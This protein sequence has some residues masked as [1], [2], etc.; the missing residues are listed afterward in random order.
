MAITQ[1]STGGG[2]TG[3]ICS[4]TPSDQAGQI[5]NIL[6][7]LEALEKAIAELQAQNIGATQLSD[8]AQD[9]GWLYNVT[10]MGT[11]GWTQT[12]SGTLIPPAGV[13]L[14]SLGLL[15]S[16]GNPYQIVSMDSDGVLQFGFTPQGGTSGSSAG[17]KDYITLVIN[18]QDYQTWQAGG[19]YF[20]SVSTNVG[21]AFTWD[22][23]NK[24]SFPA[25]LYWSGGSATIQ[26]VATGEYVVS[27][28]GSI[29][30]TSDNNLLFYNGV[31]DLAEKVTGSTISM[32]FAPGFMFYVPSASNF[33]MGLSAGDPTG[34][35]QGYWTIAKLA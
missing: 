23:Q 31:T 13:S 26:Y 16:D 19:N 34:N 32:L 33:Q 29:R 14:S 28:G 4:I 21:T 30:R 6:S 17:V 18:N 9:A 35:I 27:Y 10:Y 8:I 24:V 3:S 2:S 20:S 15:M 5:D 11:P 25:G 22:S 1:D 7:R 12:S